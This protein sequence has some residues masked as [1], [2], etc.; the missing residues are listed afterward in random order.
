MQCGDDAY[1]LSIIEGKFDFHLFYVEC[2]EFCR[3]RGLDLKKIRSVQLLIE[4]VVIN[5]LLLH[6]QNIEFS[7]ICLDNHEARIDFI[8]DGEKYNLFEVADEK[9]LS[10]VLIKCLTGEYRYHYDQVNQ[11][12]I[13]VKEPKQ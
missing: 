12:S 10:F 6:T 7:I 2:E 1:K 4:E 9:E 11:L 3:H 5:H 13:H 8:Y